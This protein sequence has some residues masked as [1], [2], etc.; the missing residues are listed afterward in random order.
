MS[1]FLKEVGCFGG[2]F[3]RTSPDDPVHSIFFAYFPTRFRVIL[4]DLL[5]YLL[6]A[7]LTLFPYHIEIEPL[8]NSA[9][10]R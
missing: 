7:I 2:T 9:F 8:N 10:N 1:S 6:I 4:N 3:H 5:P